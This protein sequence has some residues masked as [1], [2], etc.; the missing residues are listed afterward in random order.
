MKVSII[1][2]CYNSEKTISD[3]IDSVINQSYYDI[4]Y[5]IIDGNSTDR[6][7]SKISKFKKNISKIIS[8]NDDGIYDALN[9]GI[10]LAT[11]DIIGILHSD[12]AFYDS[13]I[14]KKIVK[15]FTSKN[16]VDLLW[17]DVV[18][19]NKNN[20]IKR[21]YSGKNINRK[22]FKIGIM[23]PH[24]SVFI[25][26]DVYK[27]YGSFNTKYKIASDYDFLYRLI[28]LNK[29]KCYYIP[30]ILVKMKLG[31]L[32]NKSLFNIYQLNHE[33]Y[34]IHKEAGSKISILNL[35]RKIPIRF[36][37]LIKRKI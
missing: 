4:E 9:K 24:P 31:G 35:M 16:T 26:A 8:E 22:S 13:D 32:S 34:D 21:V 17:G 36:M 14:I 28:V 18:F 20:K 12:D 7:L 11:G 27:K 2:V 33:I 19:I 1:T 25:K 3:T 29:I 15:I 37:E 10:R 23:P 6:T 5:I 30:C